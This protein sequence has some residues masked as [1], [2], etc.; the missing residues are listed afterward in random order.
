LDFGLANAVSIFG[1]E[2]DSQRSDTETRRR[3]EHGLKADRRGFF[4]FKLAFAVSVIS[5]TA[6]KSCAPFIG[7]ACAIPKSFKTFFVLVLPS[8][9]KLLA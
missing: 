2:Q 1:W 9:P 4:A 7:A 3:K 5:K 8:S 6:G